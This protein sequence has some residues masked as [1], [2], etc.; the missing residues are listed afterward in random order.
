M[1]VL[2]DTASYWH[3][4]IAYFE[5]SI[6]S[7]QSH[8][9]VN[10]LTPF[11]LTLKVVLVR[12]LQRNGSWGTV[13]ERS[14]SEQFCYGSSGQQVNFFARGIQTV[15][16]VLHVS[17]RRSLAH[18]RSK[19]AFRSHCTLE[20]SKPLL[21]RPAPQNHLGR[22]SS[23][24]VQKFTSWTTLTVLTHLR[25]A[26]EERVLVRALQ[27]APTKWVRTGS[28]SKYVNS[29]HSGSK[30]MIC[31]TVASKKENTLSYLQFFCDCSEF[32]Y[33]VSLLFQLPSK[34]VAIKVV[35]ILPF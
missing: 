19:Y 31:K 12:P 14:H 30:Q 1:R 28:L 29:C 2:S 35:H 4:Q 34:P 10:S 16:T 17:H 21:I 25:T 27:S 5:T 9:G 23:G 8:M 15:C 6:L 26:P 13:C 3:C 22:W 33:I 7:A 32:H 20:R 18:F 24:A 11:S